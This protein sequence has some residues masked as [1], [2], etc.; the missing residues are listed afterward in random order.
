MSNELDQLQIDG[1]AAVLGSQ[2]EQQA[3]TQQYE[4]IVQAAA[5]ITI[6]DESRKAAA[7]HLEDVRKRVL[8]KIAASQQNAPS[9]STGSNPASVSAQVTMNP[10]ANPLPVRNDV[11][12]ASDDSYSTFDEENVADDDDDA[13]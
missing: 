4:A 2:Q 1:P 5:Q 6:M 11:T 8:G 7:A 12:P 9:E 10:E 3:A 13:F